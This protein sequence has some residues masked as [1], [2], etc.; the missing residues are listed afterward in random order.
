VRRPTANDHFVSR[1]RSAAQPGVDS[2]GAETSATEAGWA[3]RPRIGWLS[4]PVQGACFN[5]DCEPPITTIVG[6][7]LADG[8]DRR[9][10][11]FWCTACFPSLLDLAS[12]I[13]MPVE[14][15]A[16]GEAEDS[17]A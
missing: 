10:T 13:G 11:G 12:G 8:Q 9:S 14:M 5:P 6:W 17:V 3:R 15:P 4:E 1:S 16:A 7:T 2:A